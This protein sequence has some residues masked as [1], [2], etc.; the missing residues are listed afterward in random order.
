MP[1]YRLVKLALRVQHRLNLPVNMFMDVS[2]EMSFEELEKL[3]SNRGMWRKLAPTPNQTVNR[4]PRTS[5][6]TTRLS[7]AA[8][9][10]ETKNTNSTTRFHLQTEDAEHVDT[11]VE[12]QKAK[13][14]RHRDTW[15]LFFQ[16]GGNKHNKKRK[17]TKLKHKSKPKPFTDN[18]RRAFALE[19]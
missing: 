17:D 4:K 13:Q 15:S 2:C 11:T 1:N 10:V 8:R 6:I 19:H 14:Y 12:A 9:N 7:E 3:A 5:T 16:T 18:R